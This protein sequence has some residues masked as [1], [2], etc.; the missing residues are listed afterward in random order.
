MSKANAST[1]SEEGALVVLLIAIGILYYLWNEHFRYIAEVWR[2]VRLG[3]LY[4]F[5]PVTLT[6][7]FGD[8]EVGAAIEFL[9]R[10]PG[11]LIHQSTIQA[12][13]A[14]YPKFINVIPGLLI[15]AYGLYRMLGTERIDQVF[16]EETLLRRFANTYPWLRPFVNFNPVKLPALY[17]R[18]KKERTAHGYGLAPY[19]FAALS[20]PLLLESLAK[21]SAAYRKPIYSEEDGFD[22]DLA[23]RAFTAQL[24]RPFVGIQKLSKPEREVYEQLWP[25]VPVDIPYCRD[26]VRSIIKAVML[27]KT[28]QIANPAADKLRSYCYSLIRDSLKRHKKEVGKVSGSVETD[29][30]LMEVLAG[31]TKDQRMKIAKSLLTPDS[32]TRVVDQAEGKAQSLLREVTACHAL[33]C[34]GYVLTGLYRLLVE[35][36][37]SGVLDAYT[38]FR[39]LKGQ[40]RT[41]WYVLSSCGRQTPFV[42]A[43]GVLAHYY[44]ELEIGRAIP[45]PIVLEAVDQLQKAVVVVDPDDVSTTRKA[46]PRKVGGSQGV[47][48]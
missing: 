32:M 13:D 37:K 39:H 23:E 10:T 26:Q 11:H 31:L 27:G 21:K 36:R 28:P 24:R 18:G 46:A 45:R 2:W 19:E 5:Y 38:R 42:E 12:F 22:L 30:A 33:S 17:V 44:Q 43:A 1:V 34:H 8:L 20:P 35:A 29:D 3:E 47:K 6:G 41:L 9:K 4:A 15:G 40:D 25:K 48:L 7:L 14:R 16:D